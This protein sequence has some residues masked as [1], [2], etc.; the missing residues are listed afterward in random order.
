MRLAQDSW[1][2]R[3]DLSEKVGAG[4]GCVDDTRN[5]N[6]SSVWICTSQRLRPSIRARDKEWDTYSQ[7]DV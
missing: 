6:K 1:F 3:D 2:Q 5:E 7:C 4:Q